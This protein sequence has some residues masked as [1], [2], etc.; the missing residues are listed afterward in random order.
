MSKILIRVIFIFYIAIYFLFLLKQLISTHR[1]EHEKA[2]I[3]R[4]AKK[5]MTRT[6]SSCRNVTLHGDT[7]VRE[8]T[9]GACM[10]SRM[11]E[12]FALRSRIRSD[13]S[14]IALEYKYSYCWWCLLPRETLYIPTRAPD[15]LPIFSI[16]SMIPSF[17]WK[18][19]PSFVLIKSCKNFAYGK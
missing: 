7:S 1:I 19:S 12:H 14:N 10:P 11:L 13:N 17:I 5:C 9:R 16:S 8:E 18:W 2:N 6:R 15:E 4:E 3:H